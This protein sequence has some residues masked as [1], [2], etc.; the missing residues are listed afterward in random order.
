M[1]QE[2]C[3]HCNTYNGVIWTACASCGELRAQEPVQIL[4]QAPAPQP[5]PLVDNDDAH[6]FLYFEP[7]K[8]AHA[9]EGKLV[10][11]LPE[12]GWIG[13]FRRKK[14]TELQRLREKIEELRKEAAQQAARLKAFEEVVETLKKEA[15]AQNVAMQRLRKISDENYAAQTFLKEQNHKLEGDISKIRTAIGEVKMKEILG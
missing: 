2:Y 10:G 11:F 4:T 12:N 8:T 15:S 5:I 6:H 13:I 9:F 14:D 7:V 3:S 1:A